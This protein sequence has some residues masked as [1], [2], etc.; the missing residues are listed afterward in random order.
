MVAPVPLH[1]IHDGENDYWKLLIVPFVFCSFLSHEASKWLEYF[2]CCGLSS[3]V[4]D[5]CRVCILEHLHG[6]VLSTSVLFHWWEAERTLTQWGG[7]WC[8]D[9]TCTGKMIMCRKTG[10][11]G[12]CLPK[13]LFST[14]HLWVGAL[15]ELE[16]K[17]ENAA[18]TSQ[19]HGSLLHFKKKS[20]QWGCFVQWNT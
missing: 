4:A 8:S 19:P 9:C 13:R 11:G 16:E 18:T 14:A 12:L 20:W 6:R 10:Q 2:F 15:S 17:D 1:W 5:S 3:G 7:C